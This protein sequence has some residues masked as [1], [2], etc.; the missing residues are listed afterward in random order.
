MMTF[1]SYYE[2]LISARVR[3]LGIMNERI[4]DPALG[5]D[6]RNGLIETHNRSDGRNRFAV[7]PNIS[8][9]A[10]HEFCTSPRDRLKSSP[11]TL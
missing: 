10:R 11:D 9:L 2:K 8:V 3:L 1:P 4:Y 6:P 5:M 7:D